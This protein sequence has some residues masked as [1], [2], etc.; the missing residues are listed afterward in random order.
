MEKGDKNYNRIRDKLRK[1]PGVKNLC[2]SNISRHLT[3]K[4]R[5]AIQVGVEVAFEAVLD[6]LQ[7]DWRN[8]HNMQDTPKRV[9]KMLIQETFR[10]RYFPAP[11]STTFPNVKKMDQLIAIGPVDVKSTCAHHL[12]PFIGSAWIG[13]LPKSYGRLIGLSK[14]P[15]IVDHQARRPQIQEEMTEDI[16]NALDKELGQ[17]SGLIVMVKARHFCMCVRGVN[18]ASITTT[19]VARGQLRTNA[20]LKQEF[21][22]MIGDTEI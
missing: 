8:D 11:K 18:Q 14:F 19:S 16:A 9:A 6:E 5:V 2:N 13:V 4:D 15:R 3:G 12:L 1:A 21:F 10:G 22:S 20:S 17:P 7:I